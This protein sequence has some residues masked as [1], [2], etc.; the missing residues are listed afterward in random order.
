MAHYEEIEELVRQALAEVPPFTGDQKRVLRLILEPLYS[1]VPDDTYLAEFSAILADRKRAAREAEERH[2]ERMRWRNVPFSH[3]LPPHLAVSRPFSE[4]IE[5]V[6]RSI[7]DYREERQ[8]ADRQRAQEI[9]EA[10]EEAE[11]R[12]E[13]AI[14]ALEE[15][16]GL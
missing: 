4:H 16:R 12:H 11:R 3:Q 7:S 10:D 1:A 13:A 9:A 8:D 2:A 15:R 5:E 14:R 6:D